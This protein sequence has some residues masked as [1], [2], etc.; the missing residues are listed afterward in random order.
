HRARLPRNRRSAWEEAGRGG[1]AGSRVERT[2]QDDVGAGSPAR[3]IGG[4][5]RVAAAAGARARVAALEEIGERGVRVDDETGAGER[6]AVGAQLV[7]ESADDAGL[8]GE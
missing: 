7:M 8:E 2:G 3:G 1:G 6:A 4:A 5:R